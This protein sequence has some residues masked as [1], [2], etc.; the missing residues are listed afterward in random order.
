MSYL[1]KKP[2]LNE[3]YMGFVT[4][5]PDW[6]KLGLSVVNRWGEGRDGIRP[7]LQMVIAEALK[8]AYLKGEA[9]EPAYQPPT[10]PP[11]IGRRQGPKQSPPA[12]V[13]P[14]IIGRRIPKPPKPPVIRRRTAK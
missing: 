5:N 1:T 11:I 12:P 2:T 9:G 4:E 10:K 14:P 3:V 6:I 13:R 7:P 8:D